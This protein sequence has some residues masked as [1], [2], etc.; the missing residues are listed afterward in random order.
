MLTPHTITPYHSVNKTLIPRGL[1]CWTV[2]TSSSVQKRQIRHRIPVESNFISIVSS[3]FAHHF[4]L[5]YLPHCLFYLL[6]ENLRNP[7]AQG[8]NRVQELGLDGIEEWLE[9][10]VFKRELQKQRKYP[11][12]WRYQSY[13]MLKTLTNKKIIIYHPLNGIYKIQQKGLGRGFCVNHELCPDS[14]FKRLISAEQGELT[15]L[16]VNTNSNSKMTQIV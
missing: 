1:M 14:S 6:E 7:T 5:K 15:L 8:V 11:D 2:Q 10:V 4:L 16:P 12:E 13:V 3:D 9:H